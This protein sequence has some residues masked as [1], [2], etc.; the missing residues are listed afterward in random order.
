MEASSVLLLTV[1]EVEAERELPKQAAQPDIGVQASGEV[2]VSEGYTNWK[3]KETFNELVGGPN[4]AHNKAWRRCEDLINQQ[5]QIKFAFEKQSEPARK[6]YRLRLTA[7]LDC[8]RFLLSQGLA[9][10]GRNEAKESHNQS[11]FLQLLYFLASH[12]DAIKNVVLNNAPGNMKMISP[13]I[14]NDLI[15]ACAMETTNVILHELGDEF[16]AILLDESRDV[17]VKEQMAVA[18]RLVNSEGYVVERFLG[19]VHVSD[20][21]ASSLKVAIQLLFLKHNLSLSK[22]RGQGYDG[23]S[24]MRREFNGLKPL[25][26]QENS[27]A[28]YV[29]CFAH[30]LQLALVAVAKKKPQVATF[31][32]R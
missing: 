26:M 2:F 16:F 1:T 4:S 7:S 30:Q 6:D 15:R 22:V 23:A 24:N 27:S 10:H 12:N 11:S 3:K 5:Q 20:T 14:Q 29:H 25:I 9:F 31:S 8:I 18:L 13:D 32:T 19:I 28:Y 21:T 17:S